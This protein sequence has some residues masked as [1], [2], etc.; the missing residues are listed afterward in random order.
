[1]SLPKDLT[2][3]NRAGLKHFRY[4]DGNAVDFLEW[5]REELA[6]KFPN[7]QKMQI[8]ETPPPPG[9]DP[10][11]IEAFLAAKQKRLLDQYQQISEPWDW[12]WEMARVFARACHI[13]TE[14][15]DAYA[16]EGFIQTATQWD[17]VQKLVALLDYHPAPPASANT[18][19]VF[20]LKEGKKGALKAGVQVQ[21]TDHGGAPPVVFETLQDLNA[22]A[23]CNSLR[24]DGWNQ[25]TDSFIQMAPI[26]GGQLQPFWIAPPDSQISAGQIGLLI[27]GIPAS[28][29]GI[30]A[31][32][33]K[34]DRGTN[35]IFLDTAKNTAWQSWKK[36]ETRLFTGPKQVFQPERYGEN[37]I[38]TK[39][40]HNLEQGDVIAWQDNGTWKFNRVLQSGEKTLELEPLTP[41]D[42]PSPGTLLCKA[43]KIEKPA[44]SK[45]SFSGSFQAVARGDNL[46]P[47][48]FIKD[49]TIKFPIGTGGIIYETDFQS[50]YYVPKSVHE[51]EVAASPDP[52]TSGFFFEGN[53]GA[54]Q[55]GQWLAGEDSKGNYQALRIQ[56]IR[57]QENRFSL[58]FENASGLTDLKRLHGPFKTTIY[59]ENSDRNDEPVIGNILYLEQGKIPD[60]FKK[61]RTLILEQEQGGTPLVCKITTINLDG[62]ITISVYLTDKDGFTKGNTIIRGNVALAG[63]GERKP[64]KILGNGDATQSNQTFIF[65]TAGVSF[66]S[67]PLFPAGVRAD[68]EITVQNQIWTQVPALKNQKPT[69]P[70]YRVAVTEAGFLK[71]TFGDGVHGRRL[72]TG[73]NNIRIKYRQGTGPAGN[74]KAGSLNKP[75]HP[76]PLIASISQP[77][78]ASGGNDMEDIRSLRE[79][80]P[81]SVLTLERAVSITDFAF[82]AMSRSDIW[83][84]IAVPGIPGP[85]RSDRV[86]VIVVPAGGGPLGELGSALKQFLEEHALP[87]VEISVSP[88]L[89]VEFDLAVQANVDTRQYEPA[90]V[91]KEIKTALTLAFSLKQRQMGQPLFRSEVY[92]VVEAVEGV[93]NSVCVINNDPALQ[94][95]KAGNRAELIFLN[96]DSGK[97]TLTLKESAR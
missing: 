63:H 87:G 59:P 8:H 95:Q 5:L 16:N 75:D 52:V 81:A 61:D 62:S 85:G 21:Y 50:I 6:S 45:L 84:A 80:A 92:Q 68:I 26:S 97:F 44:S 79:N 23:E 70:V 47:M 7:W 33:T 29:K 36:G 24:L 78:A 74:L 90:Q 39:I 10:R 14:Y 32:I 73:V 20:Q 89:P 40:A 82:L 67:D 46:K 2:R 25:S 64:E 53:P 15:I 12:G 17:H 88:Y 38:E 27:N 4:V 43:Y 11:L 48:E 1:M 54:I 66:I 91:A 18:F 49:Y 72:P 9:S 13:L 76:H 56:E 55:S 30:V 51:M 96:P 41:P 93:I 60:L 35:E 71:I 83:Q 77:L 65:N 58:I 22:S 94:V 57:R 69:D 28:E 34:V 37:T 31:T 19:L 42:K 3:W 86:E